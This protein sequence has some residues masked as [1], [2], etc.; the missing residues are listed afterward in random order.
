MP[1]RKVCEDVLAAA[2]PIISPLAIVSTKPAVRPGSKR[3]WQC[4]SKESA[5]HNFVQLADFFGPLLCRCTAVR[6]AYTTL[7]FAGPHDA[8]T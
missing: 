8:V 1:E 4:G 5:Y 2:H 3:R 6:K 7:Y